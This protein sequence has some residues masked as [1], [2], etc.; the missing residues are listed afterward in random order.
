ME[1]RHPLPAHLS[2]GFA[3]LSIS[4]LGLLYSAGPVTLFYLVRK[5]AAR[6]HSRPAGAASAAQRHRTALAT[7][8][9]SRRTGYRGGPASLYPCDADAGYGRSRVSA[10]RGTGRTSP[11]R[12]GDCR[13]FRFRLPTGR[14]ADPP[15]R[16]F[17]RRNEYARDGTTRPHERRQIFSHCSG[18]PVALSALE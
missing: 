13:L 3:H 12:S 8:P 16:P 11:P 14:S 6:S 7:E 10:V 4:L 15:L 17:T 18:S 1:L 2:T 5:L 9:L